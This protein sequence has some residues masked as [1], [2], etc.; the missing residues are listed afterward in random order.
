MA[1]MTN[2]LVRDFVRLSPAMT[3]AAA[4][5]A[6]GVGMRGGLHYGV[7][8]DAA[9]RALTCITWQ[10]LAGRPPTAALASF[11]HDWP[12]RWSLPEQDAQDL[13]DIALFFAEVLE[14]DQVPAVVLTDRAD[15]P[16]ALLPARVLLETLAAVSTNR[17]GGPQF[18]PSAK[19]VLAPARGA[20]E[21]MVRRYGRLDFPAEVALGVPCT[22]SVAICRAVEASAAGQIE[23]GLTARAWPLKVVATLV[24]VRPADFLVEGPTSGVIEVSRD[25]DPAPLTFTLIPQ[26]LGRKPVRVRFEQDNTYLGTA[27]LATEA[28]PAPPA[29]VTAA[30]VRY[31]PIVA[32]AGLA[33]DVT[34]FIEQRGD[35]TY[36]VSVKLAADDPT[37][38]AV[39]VDRITFPKPPDAYL[40]TLFDELNTKVAGNLTPQEFD[41]GI[42]K[43]GN[44][45][46]EDLFHNAYQGLPGFKTFYR[47]TLYPLSERGAHTGAGRYVPAVQIVSDE[48]YI[49]WEILRGSL[50]GAQGRWQADALA[51][52]ERFNLARWL[53]GPGTA[54]KLPILTVALVAPPSNLRFVRQEV[55]A[56]R[57]LPGL[58]IR[59]IENK[60]DLETFLQD[61]Q[62]E[63]LHF[64]C[65][66]AFNVELPARSAVKLGDRFLRAAELTPQY[67]NFA[68][69]RP[70]VFMNACDSGQLGVGLTGL[71]GWA[72]AFLTGDGGQAGVFIGSVWQTTDE[73]AAQFAAVFYARLLAGDRLAEA[74]RQARA[75]VKRPGDATYL[76]YTLYAN[77]RVRAARIPQ[78]A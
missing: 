53:A 36:A 48:P 70:L 30:E 11:R 6:L 44:A 26:S 28:V 8:I 35:L 7:L 3:V 5:Q 62:A 15:R 60:A 39:E 72:E 68:V 23:L 22:L 1:L 18:Q 74:M 58:A 66:G 63:V 21:L 43:Q 76:S 27:W 51:F 64:A 61:S 42:A 14:D 19:G 57:N 77:P 20:D 10:L 33:P 59:L 13:R 40:Q 31:A 38:P 37:Q 47:E 46:Y 17:T 55:E 78:P 41:A 75:A 45:L 25:A 52:C 71:D 67:R 32:A 56:L 4:Q 49:P 69:G 54:H 2:K 65:H 29:A 24:D 50:P 9:G 34:I 16:V 12:A 73:L